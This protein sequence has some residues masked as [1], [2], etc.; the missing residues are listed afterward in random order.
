MLRKGPTYIG[1]FVGSL[2]GS[3]VPSLWGDGQLSLASL[4]FFVV[5]GILGVWCAYRLV[6]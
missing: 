1:G 3:M 5:G 4:L 6:A 2:V